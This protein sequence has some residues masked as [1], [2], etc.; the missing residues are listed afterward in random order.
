MQQESQPQ[1]R[2]KAQETP[3]PEVA[4]EP[5]KKRTKP[6]PWEPY[7]A[8]TRNLQKARS[9]WEGGDHD[10]AVFCAWKPIEKVLVRMVKFPP[11][12]QKTDPMSLIDEGVAQGIFDF[13]WKDRL[14]LW[15]RVRNQAVHGNPSKN[16]FTREQYVD[17]GFQMIDGAPEFFTHLA[18]RNA[19]KQM[20]LE[21][22]DEF[23]HKLGNLVSQIQQGRPSPIH[24][25]PLKAIRFNPETDKFDILAMQLLM[26]MRD[27]RF[28]VPEEYRW[29][30]S[31][32]VSKFSVE[33]VG[34]L[35]GEFR[36]QSGN[37]LKLPPGEQQ[38][39]L[40]DRFSRMVDQECGDSD[41][42]SFLIERLTDAMA[43]E[44]GNFHAG[45][46]LNPRA[47]L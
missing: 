30:S 12:L 39:Q 35:P 21:T 24:G 5:P 47:R 11:G 26:V 23:L 45:L 38:N 3:A 7:A 4:P 9:E 37:Q 40:L 44:N 41:P 6:K 17:Y 19:P 8:D 27:V 20:M 15:R 29:S 43:L 10:N 2:E 16:Q 25:K 42:K 28:Y 46:K 18:E 33:K 36:T 14:H 31:P 32:L 22:Q 1:E 13:Q 34:Y